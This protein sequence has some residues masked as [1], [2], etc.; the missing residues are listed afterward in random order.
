MNPR[1]DFG[2]SSQW[3]NEM[4]NYLPLE[5]QSLKHT[6]D[7]LVRKGALLKPPITR[8][9]A[10]G[11]SRFMSMEHFRPGN[12]ISFNA[13][14]DDNGRLMLIISG[15]ASVRIRASAVKQMSSD[16]SPLGQVQAKWANV[17]EGA[18]LCLVNVFS[19]LSSRFV[20]QTVTDLFVASVS[21]AVFQ[22]MK[23]QE[24][25]LALRFLE[26]T[27]LEL[28]LVTLDHEK[29]LVAMSSV[30]R[31]MQEHI[32]DESGETAPAPLFGLPNN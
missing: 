11:I 13:Q 27:A 18:T 14:N 24:P 25:L 6:I 2:Q 32:N 12:L 29:S 19:G 28:A 31:S 7:L 9:E 23:K 1:T 26:I 22:Q 30:A 4:P 10:E 16:Y 15:E 8:N 21:R 17:S 3:V 20:A 5:G